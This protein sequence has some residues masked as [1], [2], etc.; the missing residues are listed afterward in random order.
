[1]MKFRKFVLFF[2]FLFLS[3]LAVGL[4]R[5]QS[6]GEK[7][8]Y[9]QFGQD[10][11]LF[12]KFFKEKKNGVFVDVGAND[13]VTFNNSYFFEKNLGW[14]GI[15]VEPIPKVFAQLQKVRKAHC[16]QG[17]IRSGQENARFFHV[18]GGKI[19]E[20][21]SGLADQYDSQQFLRA[22]YE[23]EECKGSVE[24]ITVK[25]FDLTS[26][27]LKNGITHVDYLSVDTEGGELEILQS[28][29]FQSIQ[30]DIIDVENNSREKSF[31]K[32]LEPLGYRK[33]AVLGADEIYAHKNVPLSFFEKMKQNRKNFSKW[34]RGVS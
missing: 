11:Y 18:K 34:I 24:I 33:V 25:C 32:F 22:Q 26:L 1:M 23:I 3:A 20:M 12:E 15:C 30:V 9:S 5:P 2:S 8:F 21:F 7:E 16:V 14:T 29:D 6:F 17:C 10:R 19:A 27:L 4:S 13:G 31:R 28:L